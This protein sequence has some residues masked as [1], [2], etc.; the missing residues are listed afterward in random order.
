MLKPFSAER[1]AEDILERSKCS[2]KVGASIQD[3]TGILAWGWNSEGFDGY[4]LCAEAHA[5]TRAN[6]KRLRGSTIYVA[7]MRARNGKLVPARP[8]I[9]CQKLIDKWQLKV[10]WRDNDGSWRP[11][12]SA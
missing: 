4:G 8:C 5:I 9:D 7:G 3:A 2:V 1:L 11:Y 12:A 6:R 10:I